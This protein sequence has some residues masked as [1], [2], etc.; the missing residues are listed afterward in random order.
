MI[1]KP[2]YGLDKVFFL[3]GNVLP[4]HCKPERNAQSKTRDNNKQ[5]YKQL[6]PNVMKKLF[7]LS[8]ILMVATMGYSQ[9]RKMS[10]TRSDGMLDFTY[11]DWQTN[12]GNINRTIVWPDGK[13]SFAYTIASS[14]SNTDI[15]TGIGTYDSNNDEWIP[16]EGRVETEKTNFG[17]IA[18]YQENGIFVAAQTTTDCAIYI[19]ENKD[20]L[21]PNILSRAGTLDGSY[22]PIC[23]VVMT[24][25]AN[26]D[27]IHIIATS[28][29]D[30]K[31]YYFRSTDGGLTWDKQNVILPFLTDEYG[32]FWGT[33]VAYWM[34]TTEDNC[35]A[36]VVN[37]P[38]SDGMV[39]YS[40]DDGETWERKVFYHHPGINATFDNL[41]M[42]PRWA[43]CVWGVDNE[44]CLAY[45]F[46]GSIGEPGSGIYYPEIGGVA[47]W[48]EN[49][50]YHGEVLPVWGPDPTNPRPMTPGEP[51]IM[52]SAYIFEDIYMSWYGWSDTTHGMWPEYFGYVDTEG[53]SLGFSLYDLSLHGDYKCGP[54]AMPV[55]CKVPDTDDDLVAVWIALDVYNTDNGIYLFKL[56][57]SY[58][59]NGGHTWT[60]QIQLTT[61]FEY[62]ISECVYPQAAVVGT[63]LVVAC[64]MDGQ[65]GSYVMGNDD[66]GD[67]NYFQGLTFDIRG[68]IPP[69]PL[70]DDSQWYYEILNDN[71]SI[72]YQHLEYVADTTIGSQ[73]PKI[74]IRSNTQYD[75]DLITEV[76]HEYIYEENGKVYWWNKDL[77]EFTTLYDLA[78]EV[79]DE[80]E[81]KVGTESLTMHVDAVELVE[82]EDR[83]YRMLR[84][85]DPED[86]F[87]GDI[88]CGIGHLTSFFPERLMNQGKGYRVEGLRCYWIDEELVF[89]TGDVDCDA[90]LSGLQG[91]DDNAPSTG[92]GVLMVYPNPAD[93]VLFVRLPNP[94]AP[95]KRGNCDSPTT[96]KTEY[97]ITNLMGQTLLQGSINAENQ[98]INIEDLSSGMYFITL[99]GQTVKFVVR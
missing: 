9:A 6:K 83:T 98:Q 94:P 89:K 52:D 88:V 61:S 12:W 18:R 96:D 62:E 2:S 48:S 65:P 54:V 91:V 74:I 46:N 39:I 32:S 57:G 34:E 73:R 42:Y 87:S 1:D 66:D 51:F 59:G 67:D 27:I 86:I 4:L 69:V 36:L 25:G 95:L 28:S 80:W 55:L 21:A 84:V 41:F 58:S 3:L 30:N 35:L 71:G 37:N 81:I 76:T 49:M 64:Q 11:Y 99:G 15:G 10:M 97:R 82:Y 20:D 72:T 7:T 75:K 33:H 63:T 45:E 92:S 90:I 5:R 24:S 79:G 77:E 14:D 38:W 78:A 13:V 53:D 17:S 31:L 70:P 93:G 26:R 60:P 44:L 8:L 50:P 47:F 43:S 22:D 16:L 68:F 85:S 19:L 40:Y 23:P 29:E 56:F